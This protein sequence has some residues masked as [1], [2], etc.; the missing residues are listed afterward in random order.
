MLI[1]TVLVLLFRSDLK[2]AVP[3]A[4]STMAMASVLGIAL[5]LWMGDVEIE[6][7]YNWLTA[8]PSWC[9][10]RRLARSW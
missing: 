7:L 5:H 9:W 8:G 4:V 6:V 3:T 1:Y 2:V 10:G